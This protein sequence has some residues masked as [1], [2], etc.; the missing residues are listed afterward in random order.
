MRNP[1]WG[2]GGGRRGKDSLLS[3][4]YDQPV[5][6]CRQPGRA[7]QITTLLVV[8]GERWLLGRKQQLRLHSSTCKVQHSFLTSQV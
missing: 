5:V 1:G 4:R 7:H 3:T 6:S 2:T 8:T